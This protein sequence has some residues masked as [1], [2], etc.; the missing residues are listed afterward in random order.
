M[1]EPGLN[2]TRLIR[3][4]IAVAVLLFLGGVIGFIRLWPS[5]GQPFGGFIW[6]FDNVYG[7]SVSYDT[8]R[9]WPGPQA[10]LVPHTAILSI[11]GKAPIDFVHVYAKARIGD[12]VAYTVVTPDGQ[13]RT[14]YAPVARFTLGNLFEAYG[15]IFLAGVTIA[16]GGYVLIR[17]ARSTGRALLAFIM[18]VGSDSA[19]YH[20]HNGNITR[21]YNQPF[22]VSFMWA[23]S[24]AIM[25]A[26]LCHAAL[27]YPRRRRFAERHPWIV[28]LCYAVGVPLGLLLGSTFYFGANRQI[29]RFQNPAL[30]AS[31]GYMALGVMATFASGFWTWLFQHGDLAKA[32]RRQIRIIAVAWCCAMLVLLGTV[33]AAVLRLP[34]S[35]ESL[36]VLGIVMPIGLVYAITNAD[37]VSQLEQESAFRGQMLEELHEVHQLQ[38]R[39][40]SDLA[41]ELHDSALAESKALEMQLFTL[42]AKAARERLDHTSLRNELAG[43]HQQSLYV[44][45]MLRQTV[46]GAKPIDFNSEGLMDSLERLIAQRHALTSGTIYSLE[47]SGDVDACPLDYKHEVFWIIRAALNNVRDHAHATRCVVRLRC[48]GALIDVTVTDDG[49]GLDTAASAAPPQTRRRLGMTTMRARAERLGGTI[50]WKSDGHGTQVHVVL[51]LSEEFANTR[52]ADE[53]YA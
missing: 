6:Q 51:P 47:C 11:N 7:H 20:S 1:V 10:G 23:P 37:L 53:R 3:L 43:L 45:R 13:R 24:P 22:F 17:S 5:L 27:I 16:G 41:D 49:Q 30:F 34:T 12:P 42:S 28:P 35:F 2:H 44:A 48:T 32:E 39:I 18:L 31:I 50:E 38:E 15:L 26:L 33:G 40:L 19:F 4:Y 21:F 14:V 52:D 25:G 9:T 29:A 8:P 46:E 36:V